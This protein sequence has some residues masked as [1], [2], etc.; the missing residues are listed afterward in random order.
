MRELVSA[1]GPV[2]P[3]ADRFAGEA[4]KLQ[5]VI[6]A[7]QETSVAPSVRRAAQDLS[8]GFIAPVADGRDA[9]LAARQDRVMAT[10]RQSVEAQ[11]AALAAAADEILAEP[12]VPSRRFV[13]LSSAE[14][15][16]RYADDFVPSWAGAI[17]ID[18]LPAVLVLVL[19]VVHSA[20]RREASALAP[21]ETVTA[22]E[23]MRSVAIYREME[24]LRRSEAPLAPSGAIEPRRDDA[25]VPPEA[26]VSDPSASA[27]APSGPTAAPLDPAP[28]TVT[29]IRRDG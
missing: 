29:P 1:T 18:L 28:G 25:R 8:L 2:S 7:L 4:V 9:D 24:R 6:A 21:A 23:M 20:M 17:S 22:A 16:L 11:S 3:R 13:P 14:A 5:G 15:V 10:V 19:M 27:P 26:P 12:R